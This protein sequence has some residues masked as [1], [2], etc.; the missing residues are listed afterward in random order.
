MSQLQDNLVW[1][2]IVVITIG[3][4]TVAS[5]PDNDGYR[6]P[7]PDLATIR[8]HSNELDRQLQQIVERRSMQAAANGWRK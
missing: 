7:M 8:A 1:L 4:I 3:S 6:V 2:A 5:R